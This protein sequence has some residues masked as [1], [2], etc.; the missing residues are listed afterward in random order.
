[1]KRI[2]WCL[3]VLGFVGTSQ[4]WGQQ[5]TDQ[6]ADEAAIRKTA[7]AYVEAFNK[8]DA[9]ALADLW[10]PD[11]VYV[12]RST[13]EQVVGRDAIAEQ[14]AAQ[15]KEQPE[16]RL[17]VT[18]A[19]V[20]FISPNVGV[21][22]GTSKLLTPGSDPEEIEYSSVDVKRDGKWLLDRVTDKTKEVAPS[23]YEQ[24]KEL[25]WMVGQWTSS[26]DDAEVE[27]DCNWTKNQN[28]LT[29][30]FK[31]S[32]DDDTFSGIQII[33]WDPAAKAIRSWTFDS[34]GTFAE[35]SWQ[36]RGGRWFIRNRGTLPDGRTATMI[37]VMKQVDQDSFTWQTI[38]RTAG[39]ELLPN[40]DEIAI[41]R[42]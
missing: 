14:I 37:N 26:S 13:G 17:E 3:I 4:S 22:R 29:R 35:A 7:A 16:V 12:N 1:M 21:E 18:V 20:Q 40:I 39:G 25:E 5:P 38:E 42:R 36:Q 19:S 15:F 6:A 28:F 33:G 32:I 8:R 11:A 10:S 23:H 2:F 24:L 27:V 34:N 9:K 31:I 30:A 41:V